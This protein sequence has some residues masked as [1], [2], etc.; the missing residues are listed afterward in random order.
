[1]ALRRPR[2]AR[3]ASAVSGPG[4]A[5]A[6]GA[7]SPEQPWSSLPAMRRS[8]G[9]PVPA[10]LRPQ[11]N[12]GLATWRLL[13]MAGSTR[14]ASTWTAMAPLSSPE[15]TRR[16]QGRG[17]HTAPQVAEA[18]LATGSGPTL[19]SPASRPAE[20]HA[21]PGQLGSGPSLPAGMPDGL[22]AEALA[23]LSRP[24]PA[25]TGAPASPQPGARP[26]NGAPA[27]RSPAADRQGRAGLGA[28][29]PALPSSARPL[30]TD[31]TGRW[32]PVASGLP[33]PPPI[34]WPGRS[35]TGA[36][37]VPGIGPVLSGLP[38]TARPLRSDDGM[39]P[40]TLLPSARPLEPSAQASS[41]TRTPPPDDRM[42]VVHRPSQ[43]GRAALAAS[44]AQHPWP[45]SPAGSSAPAG[46]G[47]TVSVSGRRLTAADQDRQVDASAL[48]RELARHHKDE[49]AQALAPTLAR[50]LRPPRDHGWERDDLPRELPR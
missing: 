39:S 21:N 7:P 13:T 25:A 29:L 50:I 26:G 1:M 23:I 16:R 46:N 3:R 28:A 35:E 43:P 40:P 18:G 38:P 14:P 42:P 33:G 32:P 20:T 10:V 6:R 37:P 41:T 44:Q 30:G 31:L 24:V 17:P 36:A 34:A 12:G 49:L 4:S 22:G 2:L 19:W 5:P 8:L 47:T 11:F 27:A 45:A 48:A 9:E 15:W